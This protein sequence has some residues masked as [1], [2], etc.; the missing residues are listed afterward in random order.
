MVD[1]VGLQLLIPFSLLCRGVSMVTTYSLTV[2]TV[3]VK[4]NTLTSLTFPPLFLF[5]I[6]AL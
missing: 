1:K 5:M 6:N 4:R 3:T 2:T